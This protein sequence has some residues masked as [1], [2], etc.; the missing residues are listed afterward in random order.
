MEHVL[1]FPDVN[2]VLVFVNAGPNN[3]ISVCFS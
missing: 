1:S 2:S 3:R